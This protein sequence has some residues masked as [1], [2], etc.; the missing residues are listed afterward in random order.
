MPFSS[1]A[2]DVNSLK[3]RAKWRMATRAAARQITEELKEFETIS[4]N[5][6]VLLKSI[7]LDAMNA[8]IKNHATKKKSQNLCKTLVHRQLLSLIEAKLKKAV[9]AASEHSR[10]HV[11]ASD[12]KKAMGEDWNKKT[13]HSINIFTEDSFPSVFAD[14]R[15][16]A[17]AVSKQK[18]DRRAQLPLYKDLNN[19]FLEILKDQSFRTQLNRDDFSDLEKWIEA[20]TV[21]KDEPVFEEISAYVKEAGER[22]VSNIRSQYKRQMSALNKCA[23]SGVPAK[24]IRSGQISGILQKSVKQTITKLREIGKTDNQNNSPTIYDTF[25]IVLNSISNTASSIELD[26]FSAFLN[27]S[28]LLDV[29]GKQIKTEIQ[30]NQSIHLKNNKSKMLLQK[31]LTNERRKPVSIA[32]SATANQTENASYFEEKLTPGNKADKIYSRRLKQELD[33]VFTD[34]R[35]ELATQQYEQHFRSLD[36][37]LPLSGKA[38]E[39]IYNKQSPEFPDADK[40]VAL[41]QTG[42]YKNLSDPSKHALFEE[43]IQQLL[44]F[45]NQR[46]KEGFT[47]VVEQLR[48]LHEMEHERI[49]ELKNDVAAGRSLKDIRKEWTNALQKEWEQIAD[50]IESPYQKLVTLTRKE[51]EKTIRQNFD[52]IKK[53]QAKTP[54]EI[55]RPT[56]E[57]GS[58]LKDMSDEI[59]QDPARTE[60]IQQQEAGEEQA[61]KPSPEDLGENT[62]AAK[63]LSKARSTKRNQPDAILL[64]VDRENE[65]SIATLLSTASGARNQTQFD[66]GDAAKAAEVVFNALSPQ[67]HELLKKNAEAWS[68]G[69]RRFLLFRKK[70]SPKLK[71]FVVI[72]SNDVRHRMSLFLRDKIETSIDEWVKTR[73]DMPAIELDWKVGLTYSPVE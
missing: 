49:E 4:D 72:E 60:E 46:A 40:A 59:R 34:V 18:V 70:K 54:T 48:L 8:D 53:E 25:S 43:T 62:L 19:F 57:E 28:P 22:I 15:E 35:K 32:Y 27:K 3:D 55:S 10:K 50:S 63:V 52:A 38:L 26:R 41:L 7:L 9:S 45:A 5:E 69:Q 71:L 20:C 2:Q 47:V 61:N 21:E 13:N 56:N 14:A 36:D 64:L 67:L 73:E 1:N 16:T 6:R 33:Q 66:A 11:N 30:K 37:V 31:M 58:V 42:G 65:S 17:V 68:T 12:V 29:T 51:L 39:V 44:A 24:H 23:R